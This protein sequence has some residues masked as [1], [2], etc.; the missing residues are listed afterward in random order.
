MRLW[1]AFAILLTLSYG[2]ALAKEEYS[3]DLSEIEE[4]SLHIGGYLEFR[5]VL[6]GLDTNSALYKLKLYDRDKKNI[7]EEYNF[8]AL[9]DGSYKK[10]T[11]EFRAIVNTDFR[12]SHPGWSEETTLY[13]GYMS[14]RPSSTF[15]FN[16]GKKTLKWG[17]GYAWNPVAFLD[18]PKDPYDPELAREGFVVASADYI[19][20]FDGPLKTFS[21]TPVLMPVYDHING[22]FGKIN[23]L[24][25]AG[26]MYFL[27]YDTDID[28]IFLTGRSKT[29]RYGMDFSRNITSNFEIHGE[30]AFINNYKKRFIN[31]DG[32]VFNN[33][34][35]AT[36]YL[37]GLRYLTKSDTTYIFEYF[38]DAIGFTESEMGDYFS[39]IDQ[40]YDTYL[41]S[42]DDSLLK[43]ASNITEGSYNRK[44]PMRDYL[45][46][47]VSQKDPFDIL[48][49]TPS[50]T[51]IFNTNDKSFSV[52]PELL[53]TG[54]KNLELRLRTTFLIGDSYTEYG[55]KQNDFWIGLR[56]RYYF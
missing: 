11:T 42:G 4:K 1:V 46:L 51:G 32:T 53:Y 41:T 48:Y 29:N 16:I 12:K 8:T 31:S 45:Y 13:E 33:K 5:P 14:L 9:L 40:G 52:G 20:S 49:F 27:L 24:N 6:F 38:H 26:K 55:E 7:R 28:L 23:R 35:D 50:V 44:N 36:S 2:M 34:Y 10:G 22:D 54:V 37:L 47:R 30:L 25:F 17:K 3:F 56:V 18:R 43:R 21:F 39:F 15:N 19:K